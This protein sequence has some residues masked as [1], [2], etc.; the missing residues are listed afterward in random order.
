MSD[1][2]SL[3][4]QLRIDR[5]SENDSHTD[6]AWLKW[7]AVVLVVAV[8]G[9]SGWWF[10]LRDRGVPVRAASAMA[11]P[12]SAGSSMGPSMLDASGY[13]VARRQA[14]VSAKITGRVV[15]VLIEEGQRVEAGQIVA[16]L[17]DSN[18]RASLEQ[19]LAQVAQA[20]ASLKAALVALEDARPIYLRNEQQRK[21]GVISEQDFDNARAAFHA[22]E[23]EVAVRERALEVA[24]ANLA[25]AQRN[26]DDT[27]VRAP[28]SGVV[29]VKAA[30]VGEIVSPVSA[31]GGFT[32]TGI[33]TIVDMDSLEVEVDVSE[34]YINRVRPGQPAIIRLNAYPDWDIPAEVI[35]VV[36]TADRSKAT[37]K[38]R[39]GFK[40]KD[41]RVLPEMGARVS[42]LGN[43]V[44]SDASG[45]SAP[46]TAHGVA[47]PV[48]AVQASGDTGTVYV[49]DGRVVK[50]RTV[51]LGGR[52]GERQIVLS[53]L[54][55]G[56]RVAIGDFEKLADGVRVSVRE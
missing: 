6:H 39:V 53:G 15:E 54:E 37:V 43:A 51:R 17:D 14:T 38:V 12:A 36:P 11:L 29:T 50:R 33:G 42:F 24:R 4:E 8:F 3:L 27:I 25:L 7:M 10:F 23:A 28:F 20:E 49:I 31:G 44:G 5:D 40:E 26:H 2:A 46:R 55:P 21:A 56:T 41:E 35:A 18:T 34:N 48:E 32:R 47:V 45:A 22:A 9:A 52:S 1:R 19:A 30:Q 13:V 16:R